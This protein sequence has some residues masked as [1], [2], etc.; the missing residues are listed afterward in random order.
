MS[1]VSPEP[2][3][4]FE[5][6]QAPARKLHWPWLTL[7]LLFPPILTFATAAAGW[8]DFPVAFPF[9]GAGIAGLVCGILLGRRF[10]KTTTAIVLL[11]VLFVVVFA[12]LSFA[13]CFGGCLAGNYRINM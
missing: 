4:A 8:K 6:P 13:I 3:V 11:S 2:P 5:P 1:S 7:A 9:F 12:V 10:G